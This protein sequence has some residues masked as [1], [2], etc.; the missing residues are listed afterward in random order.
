MVVETKDP[1]LFS[2]YFLSFLELFSIT[3]DMIFQ[4]KD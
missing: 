4:D 3:V 2:G 1:I